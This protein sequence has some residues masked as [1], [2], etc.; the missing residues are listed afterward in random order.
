[1]KFRVLS[2]AIVALLT[3]SSPNS[4]NAY[5]MFGSQPDV[6]STGLIELDMHIKKQP[7][8]QLNNVGMQ[9][10]N[11]RAQQGAFDNWGQGFDVPTEEHM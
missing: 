7:K 1:M 8:Q 5:Y 6:S 4:A 2:A 11:L 10:M 9:L 3:T